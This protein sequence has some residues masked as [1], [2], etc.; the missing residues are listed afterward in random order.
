MEERLDPL[1]IAFS[2]PIAAS[3]VAS[4]IPPL[5]LPNSGGGP[6]ADLF[7]GLPPSGKKVRT[8]KDGP[9]RKDGRDNKDE[10]DGKD[11]EIE[12]LQQKILERDAEIAEMS[13]QSSILGTAGVRSY[14]SSPQISILN[15]ISKNAPN[16]VHRS[17][18]KDKTRDGAVDASGWTLPGARTPGVSMI[19]RGGAPTPSSQDGQIQLLRQVSEPA[20]DRVVCPAIQEEGSVQCTKGWVLVGRAAAQCSSTALQS[21]ILRCKRIVIFPALFLHN[22]EVLYIITSVL[23]SS[24]ISRANSEAIS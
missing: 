11:S 12:R 18:W 9:D 24:N 7:I 10:K 19:A 14:V 15:S 6:R 2:T 20:R 4:V 13:M 23:H 8:A 17:A 5:P 16:S 22:F 1:Q 3:H 21:V